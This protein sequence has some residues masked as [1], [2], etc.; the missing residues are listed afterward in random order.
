MNPPDRISASSLALGRPL[1][2]HPK[3][4]LALFHALRDLIR[5]GALPFA[6][7][8]PSSRSLAK[9]HGL[10]RGTVNRAYEML[11]SDGDVSARRGSA[12]RVSWRA[13]TAPGPRASAPIT[14][15]HWARRLPSGPLV[16][17][18]SWE[19][20]FQPGHLDPG[21]FPRSE[22]R[23]WLRRAVRDANPS[24]WAPILGVP[25]LREAIAGDLGRRRGLRVD[26]EQVAIVHGSLQAIALLCQLLLDPGGEAVMENPGYA[27]IQ[28]AI[29]LSGGRVRYAGLDA[30]GVL[31]GPWSAR[32]AFL[33][34]ARQFPTG[35]VT[36]TERR[37]QILAWAARRGALLVE[38]DYDAEF[39]RAGVPLE[40][41]HILAPER[42]VHLGSFSRTLSPFLR[43]GY[44]VLPQALVEP[45]RRA[46][47][48]FEQQSATWIEQTALAG[49]IRSGAYARHLRRANRAYALRHA[50]MAEGLARHLSGVFLPWPSDTGLH[51]YAEYTRGAPGFQRLLDGCARRGIHLA[52]AR[53]FHFKDPVPSA[54]FS[55][56][57]LPPQRI[58]SLLEEIGRVHRAPKGRGM[59]KYRLEGSP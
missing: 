48:A 49:F 41:L 57:Q 39:R 53:R 24:R 27:G 20:P 28:R 33:T 25:E 50:A 4:Y 46:R 13:P 26:A 44:A 2:D 35:V 19:S 30:K 5:G 22:W 54:I 56:A 15:S 12:T 6:T 18:A 43:L 10:S 47:E 29:R 9:W 8:L 21:L 34:P 45:F 42:V 55:F 23:Y 59:A 1:R 37:H 16:P 14:F 52:D 3:K 32:L 40:P 38:D 31:P 11:A 7:P 58:L 51:T 36:T 17:P